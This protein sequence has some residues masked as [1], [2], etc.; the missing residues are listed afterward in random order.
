MCLLMNISESVLTNGKEQM[1]SI[2]RK[3]MPDLDFPEAEK[4]IKF[5]ISSNFFILYFTSHFFS[6]DIYIYIRKFP[7]TRFVYNAIHLF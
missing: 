7:Y 4:V 6:I 5:F 1:S 2:A 3:V